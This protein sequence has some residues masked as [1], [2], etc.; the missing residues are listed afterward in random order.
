M[1]KPGDS[2]FDKKRKILAHICSDGRLILSD[3][4]VGS[5]HSLG[6]KVQ[7]QKSCNGWEFW[8]VEKKGQ[9]IPINDLRNEIR[10]NFIF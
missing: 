3:N 6:A 10:K 1:L 9:I 8:H 4:K 2:I 5:I 7:N